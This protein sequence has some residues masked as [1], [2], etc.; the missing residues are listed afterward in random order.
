MCPDYNLMCSGT[1]LCN[2][3]FDCVNKKSFSKNDS[4]NYDYTIKTTQNLDTINKESIEDQTNYEISTDGI[5]PLNCKLCKD[6]KKCMK[7]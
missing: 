2:D 4:Y 6:N 1:T 7:C 3:I 5:C